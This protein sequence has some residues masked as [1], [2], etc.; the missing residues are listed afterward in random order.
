MARKPN[1][2]I[3]FT[4]DQRFDTIRSLGNDA[5]QTPNIDKLVKMGTTFTHGHIPSGT[6]GAVCMPSRAMLLTGRSLFHI[7]GEGQTIS[8][9]HVMI[10]KVLGEHGY[11]TFSTGKYHNGKETFNRCFSDGAEIFFGGMA[12]HWNVPAHDYDPEG[13]YEGKCKYIL[14]K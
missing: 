3:L 9:D 6:S 11:S 12:D 7:T 5:I 4:D 14:D 10:G 1:I 8:P 2:I 13:K